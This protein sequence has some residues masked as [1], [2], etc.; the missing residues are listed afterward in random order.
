MKSQ[1]IHYGC[2]LTAP[3]EWI[4]FDSS[5]TLRIQKIP[6]L[7]KLLKKKLNVVFPDN[8]LY[9]DI[10]KGLPITKSSA[11]GVFCS[12]VLEHL[13]LNEFRIALSNT[14]S[15]LKTNGIFRCVLPDMEY[16]AK[17]YL[18]DLQEQK[19]DA[20][21]KFIESTLMGKKNRTKNTIELIVNVFGNSHHLWMWDTN[22]LIFELKQI[23]FNSI[24]KCNCH[25]SKDPMFKFVENPERFIGAVALECIK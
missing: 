8:V 19:P 1:Y 10:T 11:D 12:H 13:S 22:S 21:I 17:V 5:P 14:Y 15:I 7:R 2:G 9:G 20:C 24:R 23:G 3:P 25:D 16:L 6:L 4:N 18:K